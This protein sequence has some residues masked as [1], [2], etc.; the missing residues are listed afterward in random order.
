[1][2]PLSASAV[3]LWYL[4]GYR[5]VTLQ[6]GTR[7]ELRHLVA[8]YAG[9]A[10]RPPRGIVDR[11]TAVA[12]ALA[13]TRRSDLRLLLDDAFTELDREVRRGR[14]LI[15]S[16]VA[17]APLAGLLGTVTGMIETFGSLGDMSLY[18]QSGGIAGGISQALFTTQMG[19]S[20]AVPGVI[21]GRLLDRRQH[22]I[23]DDLARV[24]DIVCQEFLAR[25]QPPG[26]AT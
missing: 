13:Q 9:G 12:V 8:L 25:E 15:R 3:V 7:A 11:A 2:V 23:E 26:V 21:V 16:I 19:L 5:F 10:P 24:K 6:R 17:I 18:S 4:L 1:M 22:A 14:I 20:V